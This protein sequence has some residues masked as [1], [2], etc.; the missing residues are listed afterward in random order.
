[1]D[2]QEKYLEY[3]KGKKQANATGLDALLRDVDITAEKTAQG[4]KNALDDGVDSLDDNVTTVAK[5]GEKDVKDT[6]GKVENDAKQAVGD[7]KDNIKQDL[8]VG[9]GR[10]SR[11][12]AA[13]SGKDLTENIKEP[14]KD[15]EV[16]VSRKA[17]RY[18]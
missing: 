1:M 4:A 7:V 6:A 12:D 13:A 18:Q 5:R 17:A 9:S 10:S 3:E 15:D 2:A 11:F 8:G 14:D 16:Y